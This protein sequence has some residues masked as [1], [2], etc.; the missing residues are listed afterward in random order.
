MLFL[1]VSL[2]LVFEEIEGSVD[3]VVALV[4]VLYPCLLV[5]HAVYYARVDV[6]L[7]QA[8]RLLYHEVASLQAM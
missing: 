7:Q 5:E 1:A 3:G 4:E 8:V 6:E 2:A